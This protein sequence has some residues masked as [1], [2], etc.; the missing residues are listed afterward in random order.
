MPW[1]LEKIGSL[2][3]TPVI[4]CDAGC[5]RSPPLRC[6]E[7]TCRGLHQPIG[8]DPGQSTCSPSF[9]RSWQQQGKDRSPFALSLVVL[10]SMRLKG[11]AAVLDRI[12]LRF[13][14]CCWLVTTSSAAAETFTSSGTGF[15]ISSDGWFVTNAHVLAGCSR[16]SVSDLGD[17]LEIKTDNL[18][19]LAAVRVAS[20]KPF[21][22]PLAIRDSP[23]KLGEEVAALGFPLSNILSDGVKI[24]TGNINSLVGLDND[25]RYLQISTPIQPGNSGGPLVDRRGLVLG[26]NSA[27]LGA[28]FVGKSGILPQ[29]V[30][31]AIK[32]TVLELFLQ[33]HSIFVGRKGESEIKL[34]T[35]TLAA[36]V[37]P[38]VVQILCFGSDNQEVTK[39]ESAIDDPSKPEPY[40]EPSYFVRLTGTDVLGSD[41]ATIKDVTGQQCRT[42]CEQDRACIATTYNKR[43]RFCFLKNDAFVLVKNRDA[44]A[45]FHRSKDAT[46]IRAPMTVYSSRD[47][48]GGD[49]RNIANSNFVGC[50]VECIKDKACLAFSYVRK[51]GSCWLKSHMGP[52]KKQIGIDLGIVQ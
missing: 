28:N 26:I 27:Q 37:S 11:V 21:P 10:L 31:F 46:I 7:R 15:L 43:A 8:I 49:Y 1:R 32:T 42:A 50:T 5:R 51:N 6:E 30:N 17:A 9:G 45:T 44:D 23:A 33:S 35:E 19:D 25:T 22:T 40:L 34:E 20:T 2:C 16:V 47:M 36:N 24:T 29:N 4:K 12:V 52:T 14:I 38:S 39:Q 41:Y 18:N 48:V 13:L 3:F